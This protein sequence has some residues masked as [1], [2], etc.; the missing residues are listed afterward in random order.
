MFAFD[1]RTKTSRDI[2]TFGVWKIE[3]VAESRGNR[4]CR[5]FGHK[6][7][8]RQ[9]ILYC[10]IGRDDDTSAGHCLSDCF[11]ETT[12]G[13]EVNVDRVRIVNSYSLVIADSRFE[14]NVR[15]KGKLFL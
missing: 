11:I 2:G 15:Y 6:Q 3:R 9:Y 13:S 14:C 8:F 5:Q 4:S 7:L 12:G 10:I 1:I